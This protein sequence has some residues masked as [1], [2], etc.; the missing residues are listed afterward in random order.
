MAMICI[1]RDGF[2]CSQRGSTGD[3]DL[4]PA[5]R[6]LIAPSGVAVTMICI[7]RDGFGSNDEGELRR[8]RL[9]S[10]T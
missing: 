2:T 5:G 1:Q 10:G 7:Q 9:R 6:L 3:N 4:H 8:Q